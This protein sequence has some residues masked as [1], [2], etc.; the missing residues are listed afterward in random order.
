MG[1]LLFLKNM[2]KMLAILIRKLKIKQGLDKMGDPSPPND[3]SEG[4]ESTPKYVI[5]M[6]QE[7]MP[8]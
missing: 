7:E 4:M 1:H 6:L 3:G 2:R 8:A 5:P